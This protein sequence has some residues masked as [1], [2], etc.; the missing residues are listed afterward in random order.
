MED[1]VILSAVR[2][3]IGRYG[4]VLKDVRP[5]DLGA[6]VIQEAL[7]RA[8]VDPASV[9]DVVFGCA[10]Q[11]GED[12][13][14]VARMSLLLAGLPITVAGQTVNRLCGSGL[15]ALNSAAQA[16]QTGAGDTFIAGG[17]ES[18][19]RAPLVMGKSDNAFGRAQ[20][21]EDTT[22]G[23]RFVNPKLSEL[24]H[25]YSMGETAENVAERYQISREAQDAYALHS[26]Q[27]AVAAQQSGKF[28]QEIV[29]VAIPQ[30]KGEDLSVSQDE[31]PRP[32]TSLGKLARLKPVFRQG[33]SVTAGNS[34][35]INDGAAALV[36]TSASHARELDLHPRA[37]IVATAVA[38]VDPAYMGLGPIPAT[39]KALQRAGLTMQDIDLVELNEAF[40]SQ[41]LQCGHE[42]EID[43]E[44]L[45]VNGGAIALGHPL[46]CSGA[47]LVV[48]LLH[49]LE[50]RGGRYGLATMCIGVGQGIATIIEHL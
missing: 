37:R 40:A 20:K 5:D 21:L 19:T 42:L 36:V 50:R 48:T 34:A 46:G 45:N 25:P 24:Y 27:R 41:V 35:G 3:P 33:G 7:R 22:L 38:G 12:N 18:M 6:L 32:D 44:R 47:R 28:A 43:Q 2:T 30:K 17:V 10:N 49:E 8:Q 29:A 13:R 26:H 14:N 9:E 23:W 11:A 4:G 31:H 39:R 15:Q 16:I 1:A